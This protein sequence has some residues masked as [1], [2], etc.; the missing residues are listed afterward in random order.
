M[1]GSKAG[2]FILFEIK[3]DEQ[4]KRKL[5]GLSEPEWR[6]SQLFVGYP[7][8]II[9]TLDDALQLLEAHHGDTI[10]RA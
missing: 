2:T 4:Y 6:F 8:Y 1:V 3:T 7:S 5:H 10:Y 9:Q